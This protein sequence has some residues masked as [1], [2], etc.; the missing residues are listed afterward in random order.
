MKE[1]TFTN[2]KDNHKTVKRNVSKLTVLDINIYNKPTVKGHRVV[3]VQK[4]KS[5]WNRLEI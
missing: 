1:L 5:K 2:N 4:D 3:L